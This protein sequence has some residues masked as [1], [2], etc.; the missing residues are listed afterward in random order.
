[1]RPKDPEPINDKKARLEFSSAERQI[2]KSKDDITSGFDDSTIFIFD[3]LMVL[4]MFLFSLSATP[5]W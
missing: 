1:M 2:I 4:W 5:A 3:S